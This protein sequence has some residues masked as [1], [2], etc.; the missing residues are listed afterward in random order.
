MELHRRSEQSFTLG[1]Q[2]DRS[3]PHAHRSYAPCCHHPQQRYRLFQGPSWISLSGRCQIHVP[4]TNGRYYSLAFY[5]IF[6]NN[7]AYIGRRL[8]G[9]REGTYL[10]VGPHWNGTIPT[11][12]RVIRAPSND[13]LVLTRILVDGEADLPA[14]QAVRMACACGHGK[15]AS[16]GQRK[17]FQPPVIQPHS[18]RWSIKH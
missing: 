5:D 15:E 7:F 1:R 3:R 2:R 9:T 18:S 11:P 8:T 6:T 12:L 10:V 16:A 17:S 14:A 4:D 13:V